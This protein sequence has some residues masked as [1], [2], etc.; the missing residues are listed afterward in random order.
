M[1]DEEKKLP[2]GYTPLEY[3]LIGSSESNQ[4]YLLPQN[5][6]I[7]EVERKINELRTK[8]PHKFTVMEMT[9][10]VGY[11]IIIPQTL[12][13][14]L[15]AEEKDRL[16]PFQTPFTL[17]TYNPVV[18]R[19]MDEVYID[20]FFENGE[21]L[22]TTYSQC[23][24]L[25]DENRKDSTEGEYIFVG[26]HDEITAEL[27]G[28]AANVLMCCTSLS[29]NN[30]APNGETYGACLKITDV[31]GFHKAL[32]DQ[33]IRDGFQIMDTIQGPC[34]YA[35]KIFQ[36]KIGKEVVDFFLNL[37]SAFDFSI[38]T[39]QMY[40]IGGDHMFF[41]K[42][43]AFQH[44]CEYRFVWMINSQEELDR[45]IIHVPQA[46]QYCEKI[47]FEDSKSK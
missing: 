2:D 3:I 10:T 11:A 41:T 21:F 38:L 43:L 35:E 18:Y 23:K 13:P 47:V 5:K 31:A 42:S 4:Q 27:H 29:N 14:L 7:E 39:E 8:Y 33:L 24:K 46:C 9:A 1:C 34:T 20:R 12:I 22:L 44:E 28:G 26:T 25:E 19:F 36:N 37:P 6:T 30:V 32:T 16:I 17:R 45:Q 15:S 40:N